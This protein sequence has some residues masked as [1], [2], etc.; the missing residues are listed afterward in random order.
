M[1]GSPWP[2]TSEKRRAKVLAQIVA[3]QA[4]Q[5][6]EVLNFRRTHLGGT[7][8]APERVPS[9]MRS[10]ALRFLSRWRLRE[11]GVPV[12]DHRAEV[13]TAYRPLPPGEGGIRTQAVKIKWRSRC[14]TLPLRTEALPREGSG[15]PEL[16]CGSPN[17][18]PKLVVL[19]PHSFLDDARILAGWLAQRY[20]WREPQAAWFLF[21]D[22]APEYTPALIDL[23]PSM[24]THL[25]DGQIVL[26]LRP[27]VSE[28]SVGRIY[29]RCQKQLLGHRKREISQD[30]LVLYEFVESHMRPPPDGPDW[31]GLFRLWRLGDSSRRTAPPRTWRQFQRDYSRTRALL[32]GPRRSDLGQ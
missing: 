16:L 5:D 21:T 20:S 15:A 26:R 6:P 23:L 14:L 29:R 30:K 17:S 19:L 12:L 11:A 13:T 25:P 1:R 24:P 18:T 7:L 22:D 9:L 4:R 28:D 27:W 10:V 3:R 8:V 32:L 2:S 31:P